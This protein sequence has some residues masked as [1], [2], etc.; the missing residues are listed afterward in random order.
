L[1]N[2]AI[3]S[4]NN[5]VKGLN[6]IGYPGRLQTFIRDFSNGVKS[7]FQKMGFDV[8]IEPPKELSPLDVLST[9]L[10]KPVVEKAQT[11]INEAKDKKAKLSEVKSNFLPG[12]SQRDQKATATLTQDDL[13]L[14]TV[15]INA[16]Q[17][18]PGKLGL[19]KYLKPGV[20]VNIVGD[21]NVDPIKVRFEDS[22]STEPPQYHE[23][24][25]STLK[26]YATSQSV[27]QNQKAEVAT[28][29]KK[30]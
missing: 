16:H 10:Q 18:N 3:E 22:A 29:K 9:F 19:E 15:Y 26:E 23:I 14:A 24:K 6:K 7:L 13:Q 1:G 30:V 20:T 27:I 5:L 4:S 21:L 25:A 28:P 2:K 17:N 12:F 11:A 8:K